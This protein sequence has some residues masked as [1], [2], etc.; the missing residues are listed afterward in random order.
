MHTAKRFVPSRDAARDWD[1]RVTKPMKPDPRL[2]A[3]ARGELDPELGK[4]TVQF[5]AVR[6]PSIATPI[7]LRDPEPED[8]FGGLILVEEEDNDDT[9]D[10]GYANSP[11]DEDDGEDEDTTIV[12]EE[13]WLAEEPEPFSIKR[14]P[15]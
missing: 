2:L 4:P 3:I 5:P 8:P 12:D 13:M 14:V 7:P 9:S 6:V 1:S 10:Q 15:A 11:D